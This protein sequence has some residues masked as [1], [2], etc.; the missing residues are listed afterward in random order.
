MITA[1]NALPN[2]RTAQMNVKQWSACNSLPTTSE[3]KS[4]VISML[5]SHGFL[6]FYNWT[7]GAQ[8][9]SEMAIF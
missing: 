2:A 4:H 9:G 6:I 3:S 1:K 5:R 8:F 7:Y